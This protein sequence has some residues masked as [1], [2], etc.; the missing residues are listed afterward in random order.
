MAKKTCGNSG[1][2]RPL[3]CTLSSRYCLTCMVKFSSCLTPAS[4]KRRG[5]WFLVQRGTAVTPSHKKEGVRGNHS[6]NT[7]GDKIGYATAAFNNKPRIRR[8]LLPRPC[9]AAGRHP[10]ATGT[11]AGAAERTTRGVSRSQASG[12][13]YTLTTDKSTVMA[14]GSVSGDGGLGAF[15]ASRDWSD[16]DSVIYSRMIRI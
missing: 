4:S 1:R 7:C 2:A 16:I 13:I 6:I 15:C 11:T 14:K 5:K 10:S 3:P 8:V 9:A 12:T